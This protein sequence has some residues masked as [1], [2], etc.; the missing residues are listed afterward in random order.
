MKTVPAVPKM[1]FTVQIG[2][3]HLKVEKVTILRFRLHLLFI[4]SKNSKILKT[5]QQ[6]AKIFVIEEHFSYG[7]LGTYLQSQSNQQIKILGL[8]N[9]YVH[10]IGSQNQAR[11]HFGID[12][13][14]IIKFVKEHNG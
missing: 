7:G 9:A 2:G 12:A 10:F 13:Q 14:G 11:E 4:N 1:V 8:P 6:Y 5:I 3:K